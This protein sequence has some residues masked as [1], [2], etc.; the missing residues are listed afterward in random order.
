MINGFSWIVVLN[1]SP[2]VIIL[3]DSQVILS[4]VFNLMHKGVIGYVIPFL[5]PDFSES[6]RPDLVSSSSAEDDDELDDD[7]DGASS[8]VVLQSDDASSVHLKY[9]YHLQI[10]EFLSTRAPS[11]LFSFLIRSY[12]SW[13]LV[14]A[15][16][17]RCWWAF[18]I[19]MNCLT[20]V[21]MMIMMMTT[22]DQNASVP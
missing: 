11:S 15:L 21:E 20:T 7:D 3:S 16:R 19:L 4:S 8:P 22:E 10:F 2:M 9:V 18:S 6:T 14:S 12:W 17:W 5:F 13:F 1:P